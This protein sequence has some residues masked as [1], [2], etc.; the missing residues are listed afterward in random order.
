MIFAVVS[1]ACGL[2]SKA[3]APEKGEIND[4]ASSE[5][6]GGSVSEE[7]VAQT[8]GG[9]DLSI[10]GE[11]HR[12]EE[13]GFAFRLVPGYQ[14]DISGGMV[15]MLAPGVD[16]DTGPVFQLIGWKNNSVKT[17]DQLYEELKSDPAVSV[18]EARPVEVAGLSGLSADIQL[19]NSGRAIMGRAVMVMVDPYQQFVLMFGAPESEWEAAAPY[20][21]AVLA[22]IEVFEIVS[23][24]LTSGMAS[25]KYAYT[26]ANVVRDLVVYDGVIYAATLGGMVSWRLDSGYAMQYTPLDGMGNVS[27]NAIIYCEIPEPR[28]LVGTLSGIS[29]YDPNTGMW[30]QRTLAPH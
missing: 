18:S 26:N 15:S 4:A 1:F 20:F 3:E 14:L 17:N 19:D 22:S 21:D 27:A 2:G 16:P 30:E 10:L 5:T 8:S 23:P 13:G 9:V 24:S 11:E 7:A 25:G 29:I 6:S 12:V 28:I